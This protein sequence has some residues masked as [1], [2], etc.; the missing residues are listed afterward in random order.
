MGGTA[1]EPDLRLA[2]G[3]TWG[4]ALL[5]LL[6][7]W[8]NNER[9]MKKALA[10]SADAVILNLEDSVHPVAKSDARALVAKVLAADLAMPI[11]VRANADD[12]GWH[13]PNLAAILPAH[14]DRRMLPKCGGLRAVRRL[15]DRRDALGASSTGVAAP[16]GRM[17]DKAH[18]RLARRTLDVAEA[19]TRPQ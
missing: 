8:G 4:G 10:A 1:S 16:D 9:Q 6:Y 14:P 11:V 17:M 3:G 18:L 13:L 19:E 12:T 2:P 7:C 15:S 5:G